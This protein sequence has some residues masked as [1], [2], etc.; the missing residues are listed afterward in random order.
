M[1]K[2]KG[3][4][5]LLILLSICYFALGA[6]TGGIFKLVHGY[7]F[8]GVFPWTTYE[9][10][11]QTLGGGAEKLTESTRKRGELAGEASGR[12]AVRL[13]TQGA[14]VELV[15]KAEANAIVVRVA[16]PNIGLDDSVTLSVSVD[17]QDAG[18]LKCIS[19][20]SNL[21]GG[22]DSPKFVIFFYK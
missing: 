8:V 11:D 13:G 20:Y 4:L 22:E 6:G 2:V 12:A 16:I 9:A 21:C 7:F 14:Y 5:M 15:S 3:V 1:K 19:R 17:G 10:E 18:K